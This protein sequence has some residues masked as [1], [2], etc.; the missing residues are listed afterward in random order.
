MTTTHLA[1]SNR[2]LELIDIR[3]NGTGVFRDLDGLADGRITCPMT[4]E[5]VR[6]ATG[7]GCRF[8]KQQNLRILT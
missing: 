3:P 1:A 6:S 4:P 7:D 2:R 5:Y 8:S